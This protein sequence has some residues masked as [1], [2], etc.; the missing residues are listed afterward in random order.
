MIK[1]SK[2]ILCFI[3]HI[4]IYISNRLPDDVDKAT[5]GPHIVSKCELRKQDSDH[6]NL[7]PKQGTI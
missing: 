1:I 6:G 3:I 4:R 2:F 5:Q 7:I